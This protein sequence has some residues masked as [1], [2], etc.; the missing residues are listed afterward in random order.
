MYQ[1][2][3]GWILG[4]LISFKS[5]KSK[6]SKKSENQFNQGENQFNQFNQFNQRFSQ[7]IEYLLFHF[8][9]LSSVL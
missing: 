2:G 7:G 8:S 5:K 4:F 3:K 9:N 1:G 6:K